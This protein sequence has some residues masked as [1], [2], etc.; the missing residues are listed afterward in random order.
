MKSNSF[1][2][3]K[4]KCSKIRRNLFE[5]IGLDYYSRP[6]R[7]NIDKKLEKYLPPQKGFFIEVGA[8]DG[9]TQSN[10]YYFERFRGW[11]GILIEG[12]PELYEQCVLERTKSKIFNCALV[13][14]DFPDSHVTMK[15]AN[16]MSIVEGALKSKKADEEHI[17]KG[18]QVAAINKTYEIQVPART[19]TS[20]LDECN[21]QE[22]DF[23]SLDV[24]GYELNIL[25]GLDF[26]KY[27]PKY[28][29]IETTFREEIEEYISDL[30]TKVE[31]LSHHDFLYKCK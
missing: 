10:T 19:L 29:L 18:L 16:L 4:K 15:Y 21:V 13:S 28:M 11:T 23:F 8:N 9:Y 20:I 26:N 12:I 5:L 14:S 25:K 24:E 17:K 27:R 6:S 1:F 2:Y 3:L 30:Y 22:I 7:V 31:Q